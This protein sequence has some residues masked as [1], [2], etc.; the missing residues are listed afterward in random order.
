MVQFNLLPDVK[1]EHIKSEKT[2]RIVATGALTV[3]ALMVF[4]LCYCS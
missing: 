2:K 1:L 4:I 3:T